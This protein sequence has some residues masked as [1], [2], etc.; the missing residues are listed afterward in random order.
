MVY[1]FT[2]YRGSVGNHGTRK[3][4][5]A[6]SVMPKPWGGVVLPERLNPV[7]PPCTCGA[8]SMPANALHVLIMG[9]GVSV[10]V[11]GCEALS[12]RRFHICVSEDPSEKRKKI[13]LTSKP[14]WIA[15]GPP[16]AQRKR[17][18]PPRPCPT[19]YKLL[20]QFN[21][22]RPISL[23]LWKKI[24]APR[25]WRKCPTSKDAQTKYYGVRFQCRDLKHNLTTEEVETLRAKLYLSL[26]LTF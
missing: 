19:N 17:V 9:C 21:F 8:V 3:N 11:V 24:K 20:L 22:Q 7:D 12:G 14:H 23:E 6:A 16:K 26:E 15:P 2:G 25:G 18:N 13:L 5:R 10:H 4:P 1:H